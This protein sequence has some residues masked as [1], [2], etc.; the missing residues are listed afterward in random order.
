VLREDLHL[1]GAK[2]GCG[3]GQCGACSVL[4]EGKRVFSCRTAIQSV[5][6]KSITTIEGLAQGEQLH[7]VQSAFLEEGAY[8]CGYCTAGMIINAVALL[9]ENPRPTQEQIATGMNK[10]MCRCC[11]YIKI[12]NAVKRAAGV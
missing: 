12:L 10:N 5:A 11:S 4:V 7:P 3:E 1:T 2:F 9:R 8:Q 6:G